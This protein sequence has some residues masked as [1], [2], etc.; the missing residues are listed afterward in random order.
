MNKS[1]IICLASILPLGVLAESTK[2]VEKKLTKMI[3]VKKS[4][5]EA[6]GKKAI[7][8]MMAINGFKTENLH[9]ESRGINRKQDKSYEEYAVETDGTIT[10]VS[11]ERISDIGSHKCLVRSITF[12]TEMEGTF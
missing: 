8:Q 4:Y 2:P 3:A 12:E 5:C 1:I 11:L 6:M 9:Y 10:I 7:Q